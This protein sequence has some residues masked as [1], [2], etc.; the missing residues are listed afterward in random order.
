MKQI[1][2]EAETIEK[3]LLRFKLLNDHKRKSARKYTVNGR[4]V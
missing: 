2:T 4:F 1:I 3:A